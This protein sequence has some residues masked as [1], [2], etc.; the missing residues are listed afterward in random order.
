MRGYVVLAAV[1]LM[2]DGWN[3]T[4]PEHSVMGILL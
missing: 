4:Y 3:N 2:L 1:Q